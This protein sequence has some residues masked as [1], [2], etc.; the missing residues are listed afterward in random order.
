LA[1][2]C[3]FPEISSTLLQALFS[4]ILCV[5]AAQLFRGKLRVCASDAW[6]LVFLLFAFVSCLVAWFPSGAAHRFLAVLPA[7]G[8][9]LV[10]RQ[11]PGWEEV[12][13]S[14]GAWR[15]ALLL[16]LVVGMGW[17]APLGTGMG[18][19]AAIFCRFLSP[20]P[21]ERRKKTVFI[22]GVLGVIAVTLVAWDLPRWGKSL[23]A[24]GA[25]FRL[26]WERPW[27]GWGAGSFDALLPGSLSEAV[28][29]DP[30]SL[31]MGSDV[32]AWMVEYGFGGPI[33]LAAFLGVIVRSLGRRKRAKP[34]ISA[35]VL[36]A[37]IGG[38][39][40]S[41]LS[42]PLQRP[43]VLWMAGILLA[44]AT[45][46]L[47]EGRDRRVPQPL[48]FLGALLL[49][50][51]ALLGGVSSI[52]GFY[53]DLVAYPA[54][55]WVERLPKDDKARFEA[56]EELASRRHGWDSEWRVRYELAEV[57]QRMGRVEQALGHL[58]QASRLHPGSVEVW[59]LMGDLLEREGDDA[60]RDR[61]AALA[62]YDRALGLHPE[63][64]SIR[65][66]RA[67]A[68]LAAGKR[69]EAEADLRDI[70]RTTPDHEAAKKLLGSVGE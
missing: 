22:A 57:C 34:P 62:A 70:L 6:L 64:P 50:A 14:L 7:W 10:V 56:L 63:D 66:A 68:L 43:T 19:L 41:L 33:L 12:G 5:F 38:V 26:F 25:A 31:K 4:A 42:T 39:I 20:L 55:S 35:F 54:S 45:V 24:W 3:P 49:V 48:G 27:T 28:A 58:R 52:R 16:A 47:G 67:K 2:L 9:F 51:L 17:S 32:L 61:A 69:D 65:L 44:V 60:S 11:L 8:V 15:P 13:R 36:P 1:L 53:L 59:A 21:R 40:A 46:G 37:L 29:Q 18:C 23:P 30:S